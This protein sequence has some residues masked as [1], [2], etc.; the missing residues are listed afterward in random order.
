M[1]MRKV[2]AMKKQNK[3]Y[4]YKHTTPNKKVYIGI[5]SKNPLYRW[6]NG[7]GYKNNDHFFR[8]ILK[9]GWDNIKHE[10]LFTDL[11]K[12]EACEKEIELISFYKS[13]EY[14]HG[15]NNT[16]GGEHGK[17]TEETKRKI[18]VSHADFK[19][20]NNPNWGLKRDENWLNAI[21]KA[22]SKHVAQY[23]PDGTLINCF[24]SVTEASEI[25]GFTRSAISS[26]ASGKTKSS[27]G[28]IWHYYENIPPSFINAVVIGNKGENNHFYR[29]K[30]TE[31][32]KAKMRE[33]WKHR[34]KK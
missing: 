16:H 31:E 22:N 9:Y 1:K 20:E 4:V 19:G 14:E 29:K 17:L 10:I 6:A 26:C 25:T 24:F 8:A 7:N 32:T 15:Y 30:H 18:K 27:N 3:F 23:T 13:D 28:F 21:K 33:A 5:T 2:T 11:T 34:R 12:E